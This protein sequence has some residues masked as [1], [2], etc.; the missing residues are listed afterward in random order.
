MTDI[1]NIMSPVSEYVSAIIL[2][3]HCVFNSLTGD[4]VREKD[5]RDFKS[6]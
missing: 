3:I 5:M 4:P 6:L 1:K 2:V